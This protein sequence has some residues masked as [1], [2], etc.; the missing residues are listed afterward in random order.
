MNT[1]DLFCLLL[2]KETGKQWPL[3]MNWHYPFLV[4]LV[5]QTGRTFDSWSDRR[6]AAHRGDF[7]F[8]LVLIPQVKPGRFQARM[9]VHAT[10]GNGL[11]LKTRLFTGS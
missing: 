1:S 4:L 3:G 10:Y 6:L 2:L 9:S 5:S 7:D 8:D 11:V